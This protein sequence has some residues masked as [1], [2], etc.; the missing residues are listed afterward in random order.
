MR[1]DRSGSP[2]PGNN[3]VEP[4]MSGLEPFIEYLG[5]EQRSRE[6][7]EQES[8]IRFASEVPLAGLGRNLSTLVIERDALNW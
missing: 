3:G 6:A 7:C 1:D 5:L 8:R 2:H 4:L